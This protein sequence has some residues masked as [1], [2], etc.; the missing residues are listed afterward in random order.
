MD[1]MITNM[2]CNM[3]LPATFDVEMFLKNATGKIKEWGGLA[4]ILIGVILMVV[5][6]FKVASG[7]ISHGKKQ[8]SWPVCIIMFILGGALASFG[9]D[10]VGA[11]SWLQGI[12]NGGKNTIEDLGTGSGA[13][14]T[15]MH[16]FTR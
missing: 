16:W 9:L 14:S 4:L 5:A 12:A 6:V 8:V 15:I 7:L 1:A 3:G 2:M 13:G 10:G 11:W